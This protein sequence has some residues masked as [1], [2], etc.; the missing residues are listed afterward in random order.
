VVPADEVFADLVRRSGERVLLLANKAE[1]KAGDSGFYDAYALGLGD[2]IAISAEHGEGIGDLI[3]DVLAIA[4]PP[5]DE[6]DEEDGD[7]DAPEPQGEDDDAPASDDPEQALKIAVVGRPNAGKST[8]VNAI[9]GSERMITG[10]EPGLTR[11]TISIEHQWKGRKLRLYDTA[12]LRRKARI[13]ERAEQIAVS[14]TLR[15]I[16]F[17]EVVVLLIDAGRPFEKQDLIIGDLVADE[18]R[19]MV[20]GV[21]KWDLVEDKQKTLKELREDLERYLPQVKDIALVPL[22]ATSGAGVGKLLDAAVAAYEVWNKRISTSALNRWL[23]DATERHAPPA[24]SGRR[25]RLRFATQPNARPPTFVA[26]C[27][28]P[29]SLPKSYLRY[30]VNSLREAFDLPGTPIRFHL[31]K[32]DNPYAGKKKF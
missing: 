27:S 24:A 29:E 12:G 26:F 8:L 30:L 23:I 21:N 22:S 18:G 3:A 19:A 16:R 9:L 15:A 2:P 10:P 6:D 14:D 32:G 1:G 31:R 25:I 4:A 13:E 11:D 5:A 28:K 7:A 20:I 17:A